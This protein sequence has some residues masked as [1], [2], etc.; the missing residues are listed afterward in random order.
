MDRR[1][2]MEQSYREKRLAEHRQTREVLQKRLQA[3]AVPEKQIEQQIANL[4]KEI[5]KLEGPKAAKPVHPRN[6]PAQKPPMQY[7]PPPLGGHKDEP[8]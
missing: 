3:L 7:R 4:D 6:T 8:G 5:E 2:V 1:E